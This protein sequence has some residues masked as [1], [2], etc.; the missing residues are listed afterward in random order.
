ML[1]KETMRKE[2]GTN[3]KAYIQETVERIDRIIMAL[4]SS[5]L[6]MA[7][8]SSVQQYKEKLKA[9]TQKTLYELIAMM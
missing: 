5:E 6:S 4:D 9:H 1:F 2:L 3:P 7:Q 8:K